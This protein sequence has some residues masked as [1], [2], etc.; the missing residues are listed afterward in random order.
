MNAWTIDERDFPATGTAAAQ[1]SFLIRYAILAPSGHNTQPWLFRVSG[2]RLHLFAD[3][4][5]ALPV[6]DPVDRAL[7]ISCGA[8]LAHLLVAAERF[9]I[10]AVADVLPDPNEPDLLAVVRHDGARDPSVH[11]PLFD[12]IVKRR[13][14]RRAFDASTVPEA[15]LTAARCEAAALGVTLQMV[16]DTDQKHRIAELIAEGDSIQCGDASFRRELAAWVHSRRAASRD[17]MSGYAFGM[18]DLLSPVGALIIRTFDM[19]KGQAAHDRALAEGSPA[20]GVFTTAADRPIDWMAAGQ[21][22]ERSLLAITAA[23]FT[24]SYLN[25]PIE[26]PSLR[27]RLSRLLGTSEFPQILIRVGRG[28]ELLPAV[29]RVVDD[30]MLSAYDHP[31]ESSVRGRRAPA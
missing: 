24:Y 1:L 28:P 22:M 2:D 19:G 3:R 29:R 23:G 7:V 9:G 30:V 16:I 25:Q 15:V 14:T 20:I 26:V 6:V 31:S 27:P 12:A 21:A 10:R 17:G 5:R 4:T 11:E 8:A 13:T 18:P